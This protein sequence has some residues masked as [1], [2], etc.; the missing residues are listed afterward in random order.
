MGCTYPKSTRSDRLTVNLFRQPLSGLRPAT[1]YY[2][3][4][5]VIPDTGGPPLSPS[6]TFVTAPTRDA[7]INVRFA[8]SADLG[9]QAHC[10]SP[11]YS[12]FK[13]LKAEQPDFFLL[14]GDTIYADGKCPTDLK[15]KELVEYRAKHAYNRADTPYQEA[16]ASTS[17]LVTWDD[18]EVVNNFSGPTEPLMPIGRQAFFEYFPITHEYEPRNIKVGRRRYNDDLPLDIPLP[19]DPNRMYRSFRWGRQLEVFVL[20][21]R[22]YRSSNNDVDGPNKT[23]LGPAQ[24][25]W[26][27]AGLKNSTAT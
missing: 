14:L 10:R 27:K 22:Q 3:R 21:L 8:W 26:L 13:P 1:R 4:H 24:R 7:F 17:L 9:G 15:A 12:I 19:S 2:Y 20:D 5:R 23:M 16:L 6:G 11:E 18:H 25:A